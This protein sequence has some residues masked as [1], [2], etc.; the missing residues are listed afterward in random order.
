[1]DK[2]MSENSEHQLRQMY[3]SVIREAKMVVWEYDSDQ[4]RLSVVSA[5]ER[6]Y[7]RQAGVPKLV[8]NAPDSL[9]PYI[10]EEYREDFLKMYHDIEEGKPRASCDVLF[11]PRPNAEARY[12]RMVMTNIFDEDGRRLR[13]FGFGQDI[14][15]LKQEERNF[16]QLEGQMAQVMGE[17]FVTIHLDI[18]N[19][20]VL[21]FETARPEYRKHYGADSADEVFHRMGREI[22]QSDLR[23]DFFESINRHALLVGFRASRD[24][25]VKEYPVYSLSGRL[26]WVRSTLIMRRNPTTRA[27]EGVGYAQEMTREKFREEIF[28]KIGHARY[29]YI[30]TLHIASRK[31]SFL[32]TPGIRLPKTRQGYMSYEDVVQA[33]AR[34]RVIDEDRAEYLVNISFDR[35]RKSMESKGRYRIEYRGRGDGAEVKEFLT[36]FTWLEREFDIVAVFCSEVTEL[37]RE[38]KS[39]L[40]KAQELL[41]QAEAAN[42][43]KTEFISRIS[44]DIRTPLTAISGLTDL[45][46]EEIDDPKKLREDLENIR[47]AAKFLRS[48]M[49][50]VLDV[51]R[52]DSGKI[53]LDPQPLRKKHVV[54]EIVSLFQLT[55]AE[56][57]IH[58]V[59][60]L[61]E[62]FFPV[63]ADRNRLK[64]I[65]LNLLSN[66]MHYTPRGG[67]ITYRI[68][69]ERL[70]DGS[71]AMEFSVRDT[72]IGMSKEYIDHCFEP[73]T[74]DMENKSRKDLGGGTGL[75][76]SIVHKLVGLMNG[77]IRVA[78]EVNVGTEITCRFVFPETR[79]T[80]VSPE[81]DEERPDY[82]CGRVLL[83]DDNYVNTR[84]ATRML[85][86]LGA[87]V[88]CASD[89]AEAVERFRASVP[90][91]YRLILMD[92]QM[93]RMNGY[94]ATAAIRQIDRPDSRTVP[95]YAMTANAFAEA[96]R[97]GFLAG[98]NGYLTKPID[99][100]KLSE[101]LRKCLGSEGEA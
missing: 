70:P 90:G 51:S 42:E 4:H 68:R 44:H 23:K 24:T 38:E 30:A 74:Q 17:S 81:G 75:G 53:T 45:A 84:I 85:E 25:I 1:M 62:R 31:L 46:L 13:A 86:H 52:M 48:L 28:E 91:S 69:Q 57:G 96:E 65:L 18:T 55:C 2:K 27:V 63:L 72:G 97:Q 35:M 58:F 80:S 14:S 54:K 10:N 64:Q 6:S 100:K 78:S 98:M 50:D 16:K 33:F 41:I 19:N 101:V 93:P 89:G 36:E 67:T 95:I 76:L 49:D 47:L 99:R 39:R 56:K 73:F 92:I 20:K 22:I 8:Y 94:E 60:D 71:I 37:R 9:L 87:A 32:S 5:N 26:C 34:E 83:A 59:T 66:A 3:E 82:L 40:A 21:R 11:L 77:E 79:E 43:A 88:D 15:W 29:N 61:E 12:V 7:T